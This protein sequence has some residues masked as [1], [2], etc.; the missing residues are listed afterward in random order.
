MVRRAF[1]VLSVTVLMSA[2]VL[3]GAINS[4]P[5]GNRH[6][7]FGGVCFKFLETDS[8][9]CFPGGG[10]LV[11]PDIVLSSAHGGAWMEQMKPAKIGFTFDEKITPNCVVYE[12]KEFHLD[13]LFAYDEQNPHDVGVFI[14]KDKITNIR[15]VS[16]PPVIGMLEKGNLL[17]HVYFTVVDR[18]L[19]TLVGWPDFP[20]FGSRVVGETVATE[21][22]SGAIMLGSNDKHP[23][24]VCYG[25]SGA[26]ALVAN[27]NIMVAIGSMFSNWPVQ[28]CVG[29]YGF[30]RLDTVEARD[31]LQNYLPPE[32][33]PK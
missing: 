5:D 24:Q 19:T 7:A 33:L 6:P 4:T 16:L 9:S 21:L 27:S 20:V 26:M 30:Y 17:E 32:L 25:G 28:E 22:R 31:F 1:L 15:P 11:A 12:V 13:P 3:W 29:S 23:T 10:I 18:G 2:G 8:W 14:L